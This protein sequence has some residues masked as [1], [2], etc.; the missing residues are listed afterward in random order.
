MFKILAVKSETK[1]MSK[2]GSIM[3]ESGE[4]LYWFQ[5]G[6]S[7]LQKGL[8]EMGLKNELDF[9]YHME[10]QKGGEQHEKRP[11][12]QECLQKSFKGLHLFK[13]LQ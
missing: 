3:E 11:E 6:N 13:I 5:R 8:F 4:K 2:L 7:F 12:A 1:V 10:I 9:N